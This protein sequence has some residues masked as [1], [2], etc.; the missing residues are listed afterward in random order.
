[1]ASCRFNRYKNRVKLGAHYR[2][3]AMMQLDNTSTEDNNTE[4]SNA[5]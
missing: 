2:A 4:V 5:R 3:Y 1:M